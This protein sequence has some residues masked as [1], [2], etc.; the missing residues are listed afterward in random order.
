[1]TSMEA[2]V[3]HYKYLSTC[4]AAVFSLL[5]CDILASFGISEGQASI[6][7]TVFALSVNIIRLHILYV[8]NQ[9]GDLT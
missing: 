9:F 1:M 8:S 4:M 7:L 3:S 5:V 6:K 2:M